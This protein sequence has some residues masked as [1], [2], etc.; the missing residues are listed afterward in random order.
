VDAA[1][2]RTHLPQLDLELDSVVLKA[3]SRDRDQRYASA[4]ALEQDLG[5]YL[6]GFAVSARPQTSWYLM[7][8]WILRHRLAVTGTLAALIAVIAGTV[9]YIINIRAE[10][11]RTLAAK[12][13]AD[14][15]LD[16]AK[17]FAGESL[18]QQTAAI[19]TIRDVLTEANRLQRSAVGI[20]ITWQPV[21]DAA[22]HGAGRLDR[23]SVSTPQIDQALADCWIRSAELLESRNEKKAAQDKLTQAAQLAADPKSKMLSPQRAEILLTVS[24]IL[25]QMNETANV[26]DYLRKVDELIDGMKS[27]RA[28]PMLA[29]ASA[30][31]RKKLEAIQASQK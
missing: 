28:V 6:N 24:R 19:R 29:A 25:L 1:P 21:I 14:R 2:L 31:L 17:V 8:K 26:Y 15:A 20:P 13:E 23:A 10:Q 18:E 11:A 5:R 4:G 9:G 16:Q 30:D 12:I 22:I 7:R 27:D 3:L